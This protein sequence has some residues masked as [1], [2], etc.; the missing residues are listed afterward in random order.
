MDNMFE[1]QLQKSGYRDITML[2]SG[3]FSIT[4]ECKDRNGINTII[5]IFQ[6]LTPLEEILEVQN[7]LIWFKRI[8]IDHISVFGNTFS[9]LLRL[10]KNSLLYI[11]PKY[12]YTLN[13]RIEE[14]PALKNE[15]KY[16]ISFQILYHIKSL[17]STFTT[18]NSLHPDNILLDSDLSVFLCDHS[19]FKPSQIREDSVILFY[20]FFTTANRKSCYLA[21]ER[22]INTRSGT[23]NSIYNEFSYASD[24]FSAGCIIYYLYTGEHLFSFSSL[25]DYKADLYQIEQKFEQL[26]KEIRNILRSL[27]TKNVEERQKLSAFILESFPK[28]YFV[29]YNYIQILKTKRSI[30][31]ITPQIGDFI[32]SIPKELEAASRLLFSNVLCGVLLNG[33]NI[34]EE[35]VLHNIFFDIVIRLQTDILLLKFF[36]YFVQLLSSPHDVIKS[37]S[38]H[39]VYLILNSI[40]FIPSELEQIIE[41]YWS[42]QY[43]N[44][45]LISSPSFR[46]SLFF[47]MPGIIFEMLRLEPLSFSSC[48]KLLSFIIKEPSTKNQIAFSKGLNSLPPFPSIIFEQFFPIIISCM[49]SNCI[50]FKV[51]LIHFIRNSYE[52]NIPRESIKISKLLEKLGSSWIGLAFNE[53]ESPFLY[54]YIDFIHWLIINKMFQISLFPELLSL[55]QNIPLFDPKIHY[56]ME[57][58]N[59]NIP[60]SLDYHSIYRLATKTMEYKKSPP[61]KKSSQLKRAKS[62]MPNSSTTLSIHAG[63]QI[64]P[65]FYQSIRVS[66]SPIKLIAPNFSDNI[67][68]VIVDSQ[69][70]IIHIV[71]SNN[72]EFYANSICRHDCII[73]T[74]INM[75]ES[76][77]LILSDSNGSLLSYDVM[78]QSI[79]KLSYPE[80]GRAVSSSRISKRSFFS[81][82]DSG[83]VVFYDIRDQNPIHSIRFSP[84]TPSSLCSWKN[85]AIVGIGFKEGVVDIYDLRMNLPISQCLT[86][87]VNSLHPVSKKGISYMV[88]ST[89]LISCHTCDDT[90]PSITSP[91]D[92]ARAVEYDGGLL[93]INE[94]EAVYINTQNP[95]RS[96]SCYDKITQLCS[97][98]GE[99]TKTVLPSYQKF[100]SPHNHSSRVTAAARSKDLIA[101]GDILGCVSLWCI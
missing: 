12:Q 49:N 16:W 63:V 1:N 53:I 51:S 96:L 90:Y 36:P 32:S 93:V 41:T 88:V 58:L 91:I 25:V 66:N 43:Y 69:S 27:L 76:K 60:L 42:T 99:I 50:E 68:S 84:L 17:H 56:F 34:E 81:A 14:F 45:F 23:E 64:K 80:K 24:L 37:I 47:L 94:T 7:T 26:P 73:D 86:D 55:M 77:F 82:Y 101:S 98:S 83:D 79:V 21:P 4:I 29:M 22:I 2:E 65:S 62:Y 61:R 38:L 67:P 71:N 39:S 15:E 52:K 5:K 20:R 6:Y 13:Q 31:E 3:T 33:D 74:M 11:R 18:H 48:Q 54:E 85:E 72:Y 89:D 40:D 78:N 75:R 100:N 30:L 44:C 19:P 87:P 57:K 95:H 28:E 10:N 97:V 70:N 92:N 35:I 9:T 46:Y 59:S 8:E